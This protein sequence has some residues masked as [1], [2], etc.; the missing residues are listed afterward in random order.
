MRKQKYFQMK[1]FMKFDDYFLI[2]GGENI[3]TEDSLLGDEIHETKNTLMKAF[4][5]ANVRRG[6]SR[7]LLSKF[8]EKIAA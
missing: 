2:H 5:K 8:I 6:V 1:D 4:M 7:V 3:N